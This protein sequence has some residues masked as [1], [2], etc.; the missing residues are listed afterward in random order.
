MGQEGNDYLYDEQNND[1]LI[2]VTGDDR[3]DSELAVG[4]GMRWTDQ[5]HF[6]TVASKR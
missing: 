6:L 4:S 2:G 3:L 1:N 5:D